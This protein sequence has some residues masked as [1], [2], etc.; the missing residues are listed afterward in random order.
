VDGLITINSG[1]VPPPLEG[2]LSIMLDIDVG[3][4]HDLPQRDEGLLSLLQE[5]RIEKNRVFEAC[6]TDRARE[7]FGT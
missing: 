3:R 2:H 1:I 4:D 5:F 6:V 7:L